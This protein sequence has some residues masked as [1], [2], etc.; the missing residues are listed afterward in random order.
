MT[1]PGRLNPQETLDR[2]RADVEGA[3]PGCRLEV[4][5]G[6]GHY[7]LR[8]VSET[9]EGLNRL[10]RQRL[11]YTAIKGLMAG[12]DAP[13]HAVDSLATQTPAEAG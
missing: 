6:G 9:F 5:G 2:I 4:D 7:T 3:L 1:H 11:V 13:V 8:V 12:D 10:K